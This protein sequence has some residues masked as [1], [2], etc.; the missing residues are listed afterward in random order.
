MDKTS[1][2]WASNGLRIKTNPGCALKSFGEH[3]F[4]L[5]L[6]ARPQSPEIN[7]L[8]IF[9]KAYQKI[10]MSSQDWEPLTYVTCY[11]EASIG[12]F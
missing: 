10:P 1:Q 11:P 8:Y 3:F 9:L 12:L 5:I 7:T 2:H 4:F 6:I